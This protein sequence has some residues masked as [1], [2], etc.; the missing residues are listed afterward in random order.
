MS[1]HPQDP[2]AVAEETAK[3]RGFVTTIVRDCCAAPKK[4][5]DFALELYGGFVS[6]VGDLDEMYEKH[7]QCEDQIANQA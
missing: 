4:H 5:H 2:D 1:L 6:D 7:A 3:Q